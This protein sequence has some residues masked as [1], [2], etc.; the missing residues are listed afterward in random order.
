MMY[1]ELQ[2]IYVLW[3]R[4]MKRF[5]RAPS[6]IVGNIVQPLFL[7]LILGF[8]LGVAFFPGLTTNFTSYLAPGVI[9]MAILMSSIMTGVSVLWDRQFGFLQEVLVAP[10]SRFSIILGRTFGGATLALIQ[11]FVILGLSLS[12]GVT[13]S[14]PI[15]LALAILIMVLLSFTA[16]GFGLIIASLIKDFE[17]FQVIMNLFL[18]PLFLLSTALF[19]IKEPAWLQTITYFNPL[20]YMVDGVRGSLTGANN[21]FSPYLDLAVIT[22][23]CVIVWLLGNYLFNRSEA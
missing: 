20:F 23:M 21:V 1:R 12:V 14:G 6:R 9:A 15:G 5:L 2:A 4:Q 3:L 7:L 18:M 19:P 16:V 11:G 17:G 13:V 8:G 10:V 22:V